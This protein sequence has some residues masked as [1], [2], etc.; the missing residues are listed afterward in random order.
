MDDGADRLLVVKGAPEDL[1]RLSVDYETAGG[2]RQ[3]LDDQGRRELLH[4]FEQFGEEGYRVLAV[5]FRD[6]A[7][8]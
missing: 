4:R 7:R 5:A 2:K 8:L 1:I 3:A 6:M